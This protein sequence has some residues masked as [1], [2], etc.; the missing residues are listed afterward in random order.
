MA[1]EADGGSCLHE[2]I[3]DSANTPSK[4][5]AMIGRNGYNFIKVMNF[6]ENLLLRSI[7]YLKK[8]RI[9]NIFAPYFDKELVSYP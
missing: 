9:L 3:S 7:V 4:G 1:A 2:Y 8:R 5:I 6:K